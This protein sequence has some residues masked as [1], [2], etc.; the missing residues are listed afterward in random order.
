MF[1][2]KYPKLNIKYSKAL[3]L[4][5]LDYV[6]NIPKYKDWVPPTKE[7]VLEKVKEF[8]EV[9]NK[10]SNKILKAI[11]KSLNLYFPQNIIDVYIVSGIPRCFSD[12]IVIKS[13]FTPEE[14]IDTLCHELIHKLLGQ[15][16]KN[17]KKKIVQGF[18]PEE[19]ETTKN[20][21]LIY[22]VLKHIYLDILK[23]PSRLD[24]NI[25]TSSEHF[26]DD[27]TK[28]WKIV[29]ETGYNKILSE[30]RKQR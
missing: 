2:K 29:D 7:E 24:G 12:P 8:N 22:A 28:A 25:K 21:V 3:D 17:V 11:C 9:W 14:F 15:N 10:N 18:A 5:V 4:I 26:N 6:K 19:S 13:R 23:E 1:W 27:Y 20:H 16:K 30:F